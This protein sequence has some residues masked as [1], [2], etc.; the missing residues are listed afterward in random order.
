MLAVATL[1]VAGDVEE[2]VVMDDPPPGVAEDQPWS[3]GPY[4]LP[5]ERPTFEWS[6]WG[7]VGI[8]VAFEPSTQPASTFESALSGEL[9]L[10]IGHHGDVRI[11]AWGEVRTSTPP[12]A[13]IDFVVEGL[14]PR[15]LLS[16]IDGT[17]SL[18]VRIGANG[19]VLTSAVGFGYVGSF[20]G[21]DSSTNHVIGARALISMNAAID[22]PGDWSATVA[23]EVE[24]IGALEAIID[25][26]T[27]R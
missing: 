24:P 4:V 9:T 16:P 26:V 1:V 12:V 7:R 17:G 5:L 27:H 8:G 15:P 22:D 19:R 3:S 14:P 20:S 18:V 6:V 10:A 2:P 13:G 25:R 21:F 23:L 11:G